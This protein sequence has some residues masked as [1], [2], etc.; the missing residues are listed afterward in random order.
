M[1]AP[2]RIRCQVEA[3]ATHGEHVYT[4]DLRPERRV[5]AFRAG[6]F[7]H[8]ALDEYDP[9][10][11]WPESRVFSI[12][13]APAQHERLQIAYSVQGQFTARM[14]KELA[15]GKNVWV[16]LPYGEFVIDGSSDAALFAGGTGISAFT[17]FISNLTP[18]QPQSVHLFYG[19]R[20]IDLLIYKQLAESI[21]Q[22]VPR[23]RP[24]YFIEQGQA[25]TPR[26]MVGRLSVATTWPLLE[27][28]AETVFYISG[29]PAML[30]ALIEELRQHG[31]AAEAIRQDAW[32]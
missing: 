27:K 1:P 9:S 30:K 20:R 16:K 29:P 25:E 13:S 22:A 26:T 32:E 28:P 6:Q 15:L 12:A 21:A 23:F 2:Q 7:L 5:P 14:E 4:V 18:A 19:A 10:S 11:F 3:I 31:V 24:Y 8:L 17:A